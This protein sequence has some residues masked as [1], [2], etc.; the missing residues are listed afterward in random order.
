[1]NVQGSIKEERAMP[2]A[3][4]ANTVANAVAE[5]TPAE[6]R[7]EA[8]INWAKSEG[9]G[10][11][12]ASIYTGSMDDTFT[13]NWTMRADGKFDQKAGGQLTKPQKDELAT[14]RDA[15]RADYMAA[16]MNI[17]R[18]Y[19][20]LNKEEKAEVNQKFDNRWNYLK[21]LSKHRV[22]DE[23]AKAKKSERELLLDY[24]RK[25]YNKS[26][27]P[28]AQANSKTKDL[29]A[30]ALRAEGINLDDV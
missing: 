23:Q 2:K 16:V 26:S 27:E 21:R 14:E 5:A 3:I 13:F 18:S 28:D 24:I 12:C 20:D 17:T 9:L 22:T 6:A 4:K 1:L 25:A 29:L 8:R 15:A 10:E 7:A 11:E 30:Q 19:L